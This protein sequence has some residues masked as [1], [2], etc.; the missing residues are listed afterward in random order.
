[1]RAALREAMGLYIIG[2]GG[3][4]F[5][6]GLMPLV[7]MPPLIGFMFWIAAIAG[8]L[9]F[10]IATIRAKGN[11]VSALLELILVGTFCF[12]SVFG[13]MW[14]FLVYVPSS[15]QPFLTF[16]ASTRTP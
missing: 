3:A 13:V 11:L 5:L 1:M 12:I 8:A 4:A 15:G 7:R 10:I 14:Y 6:I 9:F 2:I 16:P